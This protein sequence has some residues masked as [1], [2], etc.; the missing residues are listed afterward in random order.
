MTLETKDKAFKATVVVLGIVITTLLT[1]L[2]SAKNTIE[3]RVESNTAE[4]NA[5]KES[6]AA[7]VAGY[8]EWRRVITSDVKE[9]KETVKRIENEING[10]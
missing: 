8:D 6:R 10:R 3:T 4:I 5:I 1:V 7:T 2:V 9:I